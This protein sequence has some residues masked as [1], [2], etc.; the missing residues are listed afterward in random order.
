MRPCLTWKSGLPSRALRA[1]RAGNRTDKLLF[2]SLQLSSGVAK[3]AFASTS[4]TLGG[5]QGVATF[6]AAR[7]GGVRKWQGGA[8]Y[9]SEPER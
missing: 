5:M 6:E 8:A 3:H 2:D 9:E 1:V 4:A 7:A